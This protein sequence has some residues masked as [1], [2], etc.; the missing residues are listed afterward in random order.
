MRHNRQN[1][2]L[3]RILALLLVAGFVLLVIYL[4]PVAAMLFVI[5][6]ILLAVVKGMADGMW[7]GMKFFLKEI[8]FGW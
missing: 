3:A 2:W 4:P 6:T 1:L 8:F 7:N 5:L